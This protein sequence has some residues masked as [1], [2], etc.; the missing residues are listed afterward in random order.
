MHASPMSPSV[1]AASQLRCSVSCRGIACKREQPW[2]AAAGRADTDPLP[3][4]SLP[5]QPHSRR[6]AGTGSCFAAAAT[7]PMGGHT[8][9]YSRIVSF[10]FRFCKACLVHLTLMSW[11]AVRHRYEPEACNTQRRSPLKHTFHTLFWLSQQVGKDDVMAFW[12]E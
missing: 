1:V 7:C 8:E 11:S 6:D 4:Q 5:L 9:Q 2:L 3:W 12:F 10:G